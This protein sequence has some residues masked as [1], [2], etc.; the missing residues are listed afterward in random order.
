MGRFLRGTYYK[1]PE[2]TVVDGISPDPIELTEDEEKY[3]ENDAKAVDELYQ[4]AIENIRAFSENK[5]AEPV[6]QNNELTDVE[7]KSGPIE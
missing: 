1:E 4:K 6:M 7:K 2:Q 5:L 3:I